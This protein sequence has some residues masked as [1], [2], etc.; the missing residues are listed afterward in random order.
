MNGIPLFDVF[1]DS[2]DQEMIKKYLFPMFKCLIRGG[3]TLAMID[4]EK[5][6]KIACR[7][8]SKTAGR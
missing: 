4:R 7:G 8:A 5:L 1:E 6:Y 2:D 3:V